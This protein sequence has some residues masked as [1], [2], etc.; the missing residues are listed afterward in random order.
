MVCDVAGT[1]LH[2]AC[3]SRSKVDD[4]TQH[5]G[6]FQAFPWRGKAAHPSS[7]HPEA[8]FSQQGRGLSS[9]ETIAVAILTT[10]SRCCSKMEYCLTGRMNSKCQNNEINVLIFLFCLKAVQ[11]LR[12]HMQWNDIVST[13]IRYEYVSFSCSCGGLETLVFYVC[14]MLAG[15]TSF[16]TMSLSL[17]HSTTEAF[18]GM[19]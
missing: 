1:K 18:L 2:K 5:Y 9:A 6:R 14:H 19:P 17:P 12:I 16:V 10:K 15:D 8:C 7:Y 4:R 13:W 3:M 11:L